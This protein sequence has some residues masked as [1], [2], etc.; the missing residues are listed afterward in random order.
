MQSIWIE[1]G[2][3]IYNVPSLPH[4]NTT[5]C[6][7]KPLIYLKKNS[8]HFWHKQKYKPTMNSAMYM[9]TEEEQKLTS[10]H[11]MH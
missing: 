3:Y 2:F 5:E 7:N 9:I 1:S 11:E 8:L 10:T 4:K 6:Q